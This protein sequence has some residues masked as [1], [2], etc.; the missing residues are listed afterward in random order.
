MNLLL[1]IAVVQ[2]VALVTPG[3][4]FFFVSQLAASRSR[5]EAMFGVLGIALGVAV[6][7]ALALLGLQLVL[8]RL[9]WLERTITICGGLYLLWM[10]FQMLRGALR[11]P[12]TAEAPRVDLRGSSPLVALRRGLFTN[13]ANPKAAVYFASIFSAFLGEGVDATMRWGL[14]TLVT[15]ETFLWF[16]VVAAVFA[17]PAMRRGYVRASRWIDGGA[18]VFFG[19]FGLHLIFARRA[20]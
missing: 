15:V 17:L 20:I 9:V 11:A 18:G 2:I 4:D 3:P 16:T 5:K 1:T 13:L 8:H 10:A 12:V 14:W 6:W 7:A 19:L